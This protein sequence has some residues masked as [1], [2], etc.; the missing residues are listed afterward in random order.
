[1]KGLRRDLG[2]REHAPPYESVVALVEESKRA[3]EGYLRAP[4]ALRP[5]EIAKQL[6]LLSK[7]LTN[8]AGVA[9]TLGEQGWL[10]MAI[11]SGA[12][13]EAAA[14]D[15]TRHLLYLERLA[16]W[17]IKAAETAEDLAES[18]EDHRGGRTPDYNLRS[19]VAHLVQSYEQILGVFPT[20][21]ID[22]NTG[23]A[24]TGVAAFIKRALK[25]HAP[26]GRAFKPRLI[27]EMVR[28][29]LPVRDIQSFEPPP[30]PEVE[31]ES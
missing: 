17:S 5:A 20:L 1:M 2:R 7:H 30:F 16:A 26:K 29:A 12:N 11:S 31:L 8:A 3:I 10:I 27:D 18:A 21:T 25:C 15:F 14:G 9:S 28:W 13:R 19:L 23:L 24:K 22:P 4:K 6:T